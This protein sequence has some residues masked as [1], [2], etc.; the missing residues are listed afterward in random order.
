MSDDQDGADQSTFG[1]LRR[2]AAGVFD[3]D[4]VKDAFETTKGIASRGGQV[5]SSIYEGAKN[6]VTQEEAWGQMAR[7]IEEL[8]DVVRVQHA[9]ILDLLTRVA[10]LEAQ[11]ARAAGPHQP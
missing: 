10:Q 9:M 1:K 5:V 11:A 7:S 8:T 4:V 2:T 3:A 6:T